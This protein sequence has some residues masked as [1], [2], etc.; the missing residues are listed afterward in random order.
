MYHG[1][2]LFGYRYVQMNRKIARIQ[3]NPSNPGYHP[4]RMG[5]NGPAR[6][7]MPATSAGFTQLHGLGGFGQMSCGWLLVG[8][9]G[10]MRL[11]V[12]VDSCIFLG[13]ILVLG[14]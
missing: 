13:G 5:G 14:L 10:Q 6:E 2:H 4:P 1:P 7:L 12:E 11:E 3:P 9:M 8:Q